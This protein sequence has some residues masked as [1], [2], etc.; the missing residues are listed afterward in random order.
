MGRRKFDKTVLLVAVAG[1][2]ALTLTYTQSCT[3]SNGPTR[4]DIPISQP[5]P[6]TASSVQPQV[7]PT[8][9]PEENVK[10]DNPGPSSFDGKDCK[11][12]LS[13][14]AQNSAKLIH[15]RYTEPLNDNVVYLRTTFLI[16]AGGSIN[17]PS[18]QAVFEANPNEWLF[19]LPECGRWSQ[20]VQC[21]FVAGE[22]EQLA[23][24]FANV[25]LV[26]NSEECEECVEWEEPKVTRDLVCEDEVQQSP[27]E[28]KCFVDCELTI[29]RAW[30]CQEPDVKTEP[31][32][33][34]VECPECEVEWTF[35]HSEFEWEEWGECGDQD[36]TASTDQCKQSRTGTR[37]DI[38]IN[39]CDDRTRT[40]EVALH[41]SQSC[42][43]EETE[44]IC[45]VSNKGGRD[46]QMN[47]VLTQNGHEQHLDATKFC[48]PDFIGA[49]SCD[50]AI[51]AAEACGIVATGGFFCK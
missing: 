41:E 1:V 10:G 50:A 45:H 35:S 44:R 3:D 51:A 39:K 18:A 30:N 38:Y 28:G 11:G 46:G 29:T 48:P 37:F 9:A 23:G 7:V 19:E 43:C 26:D 32:R 24:Q 17:V 5:A 33:K 27:R 31:H 49:C 15:V 42:D 8:P 34:P 14:T 13:T 4:P 12:V 20:Q 21:D 40:D 36:F 25:A 47:L 22:G 6:P 2:L 16:P